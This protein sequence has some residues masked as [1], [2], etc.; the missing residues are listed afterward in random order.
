MI[1]RCSIVPFSRSPSRSDENASFVRATPLRSRCGLVQL[2]G[3]RV[4]EHARVGRAARIFLRER[5]PLPVDLIEPHLHADLG[6]V[7]PHRANHHAIGAQLAPRF[8]G[9]G[10]ERR[11]GRHVRVFLARDHVELALERHVVEQHFTQQLRDLTRLGVGRERN[12]V[13]HG[14][15]WRSAADR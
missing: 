2:V 9:H 15:L 14:E 5:G 11:R 10:F 6:A 3:D 1:V 13:G 4:R 7:L 12:E 8:V